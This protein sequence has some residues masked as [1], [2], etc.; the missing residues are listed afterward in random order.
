MEQGTPAM[1]RLYEA[2][3]Q[4]FIS[5]LAML[6]VRCAIRRRELEG[7]LSKTDALSAIDLLNAEL[8]YVIP[9]KIEESVFS[10]AAEIVDRHRLRSLDAALNVAS[11]GIAISFV[12]CDERLLRAAESEGLSTIDPNFL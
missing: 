1:V 8:D 9:V 7:D 3:R 5:I 6:E 4:N 2:E 12:S 10:I 11:Q